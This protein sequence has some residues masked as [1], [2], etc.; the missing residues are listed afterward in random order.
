MNKILGLLPVAAALMLTACSEDYM[1][2]NT[3]APEEPTAEWKTI[4]FTATVGGDDASTRA[5]LDPDDNKTLTFLSSDKLYVWGTNVKGVLTLASG[6]GTA[7]ATFEGTLSYTG[8]APAASTELNATLIDSDATTE[9]TE[10]TVNADGSVTINYPTGTGNDFP[11]WATDAV[12]KYSFLTTET[13]ATYGSPSF[14]LKQQTAFLNFKIYVN[15]SNGVGSGEKR[16]VSFTNG[17]TTISGQGTIDAGCSYIG[18]V[19]PMAKGTVLSDATVTA[20][21]YSFTATRSITNATLDAKVYTIERNIINVGDVITTDNFVYP[22]S[23]AATAASKTPVAMIAHIGAINHYCYKFLA[24]ALEDFNSGGRVNFPTAN[25][26]AS[27]NN[28]LAKW[29]ASHAITLNSTTYNTNAL[30]GVSGN[31]YDEVTSSTTVSSQTA[32]GSVIKGWRIP[33]I[34]DWRYMMAGLTSKMT[35][36]YSATDPVGIQNSVEFYQNGTFIFD[37][38]NTAYGLGLKSGFMS[39]SRVSE[40]NTLLWYIS[41]NSGSQNYFKR[42]YIDNTGTA[43]YYG[44]AVFAY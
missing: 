9:D 4:P 6:A 28:S 3:N 25:G 18:F 36:A 12:R 15:E 33:S 37:V 16:N 7:S 38:I 20:Q 32:T 30:A 2:E 1:T 39:S 14:T 43:N 34:T 23:A 42:Y 8:S 41:S 40:D 13:P 17:L 24:I 44:R 22:T 10:Y 35:P 11:R 19:I 27:T 29:A 26:D 31:I 21:G 5:A